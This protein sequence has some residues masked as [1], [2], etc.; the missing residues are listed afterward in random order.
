MPAVL[1]R[2]ARARARAG[3]WASE[4]QCADLLAVESDNAAGDKRPFSHPQTAGMC[5]Q[6]REGGG[7]GAPSCGN[8]TWYRRPRRACRRA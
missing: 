1:G 3:T 4:D 5:A 7:G 2:S 8:E 6:G